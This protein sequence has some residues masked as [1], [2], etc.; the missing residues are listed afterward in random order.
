MKIAGRAVKACMEQIGPKTL[1]IAVLPVE[2]SVKDVFSTIDLDAREWGEP[3]V[4]V[5]R[6]YCGE[7]TVGDFTVK[8]AQDLHF[9]VLRDGKLIQKVSLCS[10]T[11]YVH[12][13][14]GE[15]ALFGLGHGFKKHANRRGA[16]FDLRTNGQVRGIIR[17]YSATSPT[18]LVVSTEGWAV[19]FHQPWKGAIDLTGEN[20]VFEKLMKPYADIF[21]VACDEPAD[22]A[23]EYYRFTGL[24]PMP[25]KYAFGYQQSYRTL[26]HNGIN[27]VELTAQYMR[28][29]DLPCDTLIYLGTGY[30][31]HGWNTYNGEFGWDNVA[32]PTPKETME[33]LHDMGYKISLHVTRCFTG[34]HGRISDENVSP[35]E[36]DHVKNYWKLHEELYETAKNEVWWPDD[37]DEVDMAQRLCRHRLY[38][39]GSLAL[40]PDVRPFQMQRNTFPG[41]NKWGGIIWTGDVNSEWETL[42]NQTPIGINVA[43]SCSPYW[44]AD[45]GGFFCTPEY[46][47]ELFLRWWQSS[48]FTPFFRGHGRP[49][50]LH[51]P[52]GWEMFPNNDEIALELSGVE[53]SGPPTRFPEEEK[54]VE[55]LCRKYLHLRY[56]LIP[57]IYNLS[58]EACDGM[59]IMR[60]LWYYYPQ[61]EKAIAI[62]QQ[63]L[64]GRSLM[65]CPVYEKGATTREVYLPAGDAWID[66]WTGKRYEGGQTITADAPLE[67]IPL[68]VRA[69]GMLA[70]AP[71]VP[72]I[73]KE[74]PETHETV[75][76]TV[77]EGADG[78]YTLYEDD[79]ISLGYQRGE[80]TTTTFRW[81]DAEGT[82]TAEGTSTLF[83]DTDREIA[84]ECVPSGRK[85]TVRVSY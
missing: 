20:G 36:Y 47:Y 3:A 53:N 16:R 12:F 57:Y 41:A 29:H 6:P 63:Y 44:G 15:G 2:E 5:D 70:T 21:V 83:P 17:N 62:D 32:F 56:S 77:Y 8:M 11:G 72:F 31:D 82:L 38:Y 40:N 39:E 13:P 27:Y 69:G 79:G 7:L 65:V 19:Y 46:D 25:P 24:P 50:V 71:V 51:N 67:I 84:Y 10:E 43:L 9:E 75:S 81:N 60:P 76:I 68:F 45:T 37:A 78:E 42:K 33:K 22:A 48:T 61:D 80:C 55:P 66:Y 73:P 59:P 74:K 52:W 58:H 14:L 18:P 85:G 34:L 30:C 64:L 28:D 54:Q 26:F 35:L 49:S 23:R 4:A 1:R